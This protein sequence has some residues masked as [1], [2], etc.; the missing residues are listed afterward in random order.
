MS[1]DD[2]ISSFQ[3][4]R[5]QAAFVGEH[6]DLQVWMFLQGLAPERLRTACLTNVPCTLQE[7]IDVATR[8]DPVMGF[9]QFFTQ[10]QRRGSD[11]T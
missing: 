8:L 5:S 4:L 6:D 3:K 11:R 2:Y 7:A 9:T 10:N 1:L